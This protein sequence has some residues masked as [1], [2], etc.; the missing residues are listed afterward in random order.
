[1][2][3]IE[4]KGKYT[5]AKVMVDY[6]HISAMSQI[7]EF[8]NHPAF[9]NLVIIMPDTHA[10]K[11]AVI[12][13]TMELP[14][15]VIPNVIG[16]DINCGMLTFRIEDP[17]RA[18]D[19]VPSLCSIIDR[20]IRKIIPFGTNVHTNATHNYKIDKF[21]WKKVTEQGRLFTM[22]FNKRYNTKFD[23]PIY[24]VN[25]FRGKCEK[26]GMNMERAIRSIGTL[27]G[28]NHFIEVGRCEA[29]K[30]WVTIHSGSR[31]FGSKIA[32]FW[33]K[34]ASKRHM[35]KNHDGMAR[36]VIKIKKTCPKEQWQEKILEAKS[37]Y[38][39]VPK[40]LEYLED[41]DMFN[42]LTD[43]VFAQ[44]YA[45]EN[46]RVMKTLVTY[47]LGL[48]EWGW[49]ASSSHNYIDFKDFIIRK[50]AISAYEHEDIIIPLNMEEGTL[51]CKGKGNK[52][53]NYSAPHGAGRLMS[54]TDAK[55][56]AKKKGTLQKAKIR[57]EENGV[58]A[59]HLPV[60]E[61]KEAYKD[62]EMIKN[63]IAPTA[64]IIRRIKPIIA[65]KD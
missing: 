44:A 10:G 53:W 14:D 33:Q 34:V 45:D 21:P 49:E 19:L 51:I 54:R 40:G 56:E 48:P 52:E 27:G 17:F 9:V 31:Q 46:R 22:A 6:V 26:I 60:D 64:K 23:I 2:I 57:M 62:S 28:G 13:F 25:W 3:P 61:L 41:S 59:S 58:F 32:G 30:V 20:Q 24:D 18:K 4:V 50:G 5:T 12:G 65:M 37:K 8:I 16:V 38:K 29:D 43:M 36:E 47:I 39:F 55:K 7:H 42:Y 11:G 63:A 35:S 1:M 15:K